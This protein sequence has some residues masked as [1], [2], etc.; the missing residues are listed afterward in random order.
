MEL[1]VG[2]LHSWLTVQGPFR[3]GQAPGVVEEVGSRF[4]ERI[5]G[6]DKEPHLVEGSLVHQLAGQTD[7]SYMDGIETASKDTYSHERKSLTNFRVSASASAKSSLTTT[8]SNLSA[9]VSS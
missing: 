8:W 2:S 3:Y 9:K 4:L 1:I 7:M 5:E 6:R